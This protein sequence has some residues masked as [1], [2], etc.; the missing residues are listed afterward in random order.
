MLSS[1]KRTLKS[2]QIGMAITNHLISGT[3]GTPAD[4][5][6]D[7]LYVDS[8]TDNGVGSWTINMKHASLRDLAVAGLAS[9]TSGAI[10][11]VSAV[12]ESSITVGA[13]DPAGAAV[14]A[15]FYITV[16]HATTFADKL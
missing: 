9:A 4:S 5:G 3:A 2:R 15:D 7:A 11:H 8:I 12:D 16:L 6:E 13:V 14:D 10:L 1:I